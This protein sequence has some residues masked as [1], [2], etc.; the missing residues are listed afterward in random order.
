MS[1]QTEFEGI[2]ANT[3]EQGKRR[4]AEGQPIWLVVH[5]ADKAGGYY[6]VVEAV[7][8]T[9]ERC[10]RDR[11]SLGGVRVRRTCVELTH[12]RNRCGRLAITTAASSQITGRA[13]RDGVGSPNSP[14]WHCPR[15]HRARRSPTGASRLMATSKRLAVPKDWSDVSILGRE[16]L[17]RSKDRDHDVIGDLTVDKRCRHHGVSIERKYNLLRLGIED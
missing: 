7:R 6:N 12:R 3:T 5:E 8:H 1:P 10:W 17:V 15:R 2:R 4:D 16:W 13:A 9:K 11:R 14:E